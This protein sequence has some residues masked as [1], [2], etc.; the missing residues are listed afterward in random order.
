MTTAVTAIG[1]PASENGWISVPQRL[2]T[3]V[4]KAADIGES[5]LTNAPT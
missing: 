5:N 1:P 4:P 2:T 3:I